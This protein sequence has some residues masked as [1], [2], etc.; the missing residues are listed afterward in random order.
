[1]KVTTSVQL[2]EDLLEAID[3]RARY[4]REDRSS[5]IEAAIRAFIFRPE[6]EGIGDSEILNRCADDL[7]LEAEDVL[8]YQVIP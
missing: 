4:G 3:D 2:S 7:N 6:A 8:A 5:V 1:M